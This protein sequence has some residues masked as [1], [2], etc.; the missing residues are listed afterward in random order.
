MAN[1]WHGKLKTGFF[2]SF[3]TDYKDSLPVFYRLQRLSLS[4]SLP[5]SEAIIIFLESQFQSTKLLLLLFC[6]LFTVWFLRKLR[7]RIETSNLIFSLLPFSRNWKSYFNFTW[8]IHICY[9]YFTLER[10][11]KF[12][13]RFSFRFLCFLS[14]QTQFGG[15]YFVV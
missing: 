15:L 2:L 11:L 5:I 9:C 13:I 4:L 7:K 6:S 1:C 12:Q 8:Y 10:I 14:C 3:L